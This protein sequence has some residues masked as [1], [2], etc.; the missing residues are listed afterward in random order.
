MLRGSLSFLKN[1]VNFSRQPVLHK[2][3]YSV[4]DSFFT[5]AALML[6]KIF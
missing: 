5:K 3:D 6:F 1:L 2:K 4:R